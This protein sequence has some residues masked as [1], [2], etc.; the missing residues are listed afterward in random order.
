MT[1]TEQQNRIIHAFTT[2]GACWHEFGGYA[3]NRVCLKC[4]EL[5]NIHHIPP[6][7]TS[8]PHFDAFLRRL[9]GEEKMY[10]RF[11]G[12][13]FHE[14]YKQDHVDRIGIVDTRL[15]VPYFFHPDHRE[16]FLTLFLEF[17]ALPETQ[18]DFGWERC[19]QGIWEGG[20]CY[21]R[22]CDRWGECTG[23]VPRPWLKVMK[24]SR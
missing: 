20:A 4:D 11:E 3:G 17:L 6:S 7:Y 24:E 23:K 1:L 15:F 14:K 8:Q 13:L 12:W 2:D 21:N 16:R 10:R 9:F 5:I 18:R 19:K 22:G